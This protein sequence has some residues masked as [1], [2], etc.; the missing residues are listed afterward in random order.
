MLSA[1]VEFRVCD[2]YYVVSADDG[3]ARLAIFISGGG[4]ALGSKQ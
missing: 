2:I 3:S 4:A 1:Y